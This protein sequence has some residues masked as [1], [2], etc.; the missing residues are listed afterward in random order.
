MGKKCL[1]KGCKLETRCWRFQ[2]AGCFSK[3]FY[4][5]FNNGST[6]EI[7]STTLKVL[8]GQLKEIKIGF[9]ENISPRSSEIR[10]LFKLPAAL[11]I[12]VEFL[13]EIL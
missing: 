8:T 3:A 2:C 11:A 6:H 10:Y 9:V 13:E 1:L 12:F 4:Q 5:L 7:D